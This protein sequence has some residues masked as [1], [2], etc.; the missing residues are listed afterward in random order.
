MKTNIPITGSSSSLPS[1]NRCQD[2][3]VGF[4]RRAAVGPPRLI[5]IGLALLC[6]LLFPWPGFTAE[7]LEIRAIQGNLFEVNWA[8]PD[9]VLE[10]AVDASGPW[11]SVSGATSPYLSATPTARGFFRLRPTEGPRLFQ[12]ALIANNGSHLVAEGGGGREVLA[13]RGAIGPWET[14]RLFNKTRPGEEP[15]HGDSVVLQAWNGRWVSAAGGGGGSVNAELGWIEAST[16]FTIERVSGAGAIRSGEQVALRAANGNYVVAEG[17]G[18]GV[19]NANRT[20]RDVWETFT[21]KIFRPQLIRLRSSTGRYVTA[22]NGGGAEVTANREQVGLW[23]TF[24]L[25]NLSRPDRGIAVGDSVALQGWSGNFV[26][27]SSST[28]DARANSATE[29]AIFRVGSFPGGVIGHGHRM[30]LRSE[31]NLRFVSAHDG[32]LFADRSAAAADSFF[33]LEVADQA[34]IDFGWIPNGTALP[35]RPFESLP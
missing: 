14:F 31:A 29:D 23:E 12:I 21:I 28:L 10:Q 7:R 9:W 11:T 33:T 22:E 18:G 3:F 25:L 26:R 27:V 6:F 16:T 19:V 4:R 24:S 15:R 5:T 20:V 1:S 13:N 2:R 8:N 30:S 35:G 34:G 32:R 17:G